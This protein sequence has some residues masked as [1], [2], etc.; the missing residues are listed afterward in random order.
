MGV[1]GTNRISTSVYLCRHF[2]CVGK[3]IYPKSLLWE[4]PSNEYHQELDQGK[5]HDRISDHAIVEM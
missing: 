5:Q 3:Q 4:L 1:V 2:R